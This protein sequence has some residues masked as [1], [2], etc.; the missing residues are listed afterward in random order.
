LFWIVQFVWLVLYQTKNGEYWAT[1]ALL[2]ISMLVLIWGAVAAHKEAHVWMVSHTVRFHG[3][4]LILK[5]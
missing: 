5:S 4:K 1:L 2:P 3:G